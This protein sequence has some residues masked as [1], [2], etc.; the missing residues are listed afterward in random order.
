[1][2]NEYFS[3]TVGFGVFTN[4]SYSTDQEL[5]KLLGPQ[6]YLMEGARELPN[7]KSHKV[8]IYANGEVYEGKYLLGMVSN[9]IRVAGMTGI[10]GDDIEMDDGMFEL[11]LLKEPKDLPG[12]GELAASFLITH[13]KSEHI[14]RIKT[15]E[16]R[17]VSEEPLEWVKDGEFGGNLQEV[18][19]RVLPHALRVIKTY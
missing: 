15:P 13:E 16:V 17:F 8:K 12:W 11:N 10:W 7:M 1:M 18:T 14:V 2:N 6:A 5:K 19:V 3:Y 4:V 9:S